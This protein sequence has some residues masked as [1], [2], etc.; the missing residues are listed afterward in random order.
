MPVYHHL[1]HDSDQHFIL[2][3]GTMSIV[4]HQYIFKGAWVR[5][6]KS[7]TTVPM[8]DA[9]AENIMFDQFKSH[10]TTWGSAG[11]PEW[12]NAVFGTK[13]GQLAWVQFKYSCASPYCTSDQM[14]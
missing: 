12:F 14:C 8:G 3:T 5:D 11:H 6:L 13:D 4:R 1:E 2:H 9:Q 7:D 10:S